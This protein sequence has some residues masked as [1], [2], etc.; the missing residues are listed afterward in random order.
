[1]ETRAAVTMATAIHD[2][3]IADIVELVTDDDSSTRANLKHPYGSWK[4]HLE[5]KTLAQEC[6][7]KIS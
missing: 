1:M 5:Q 2:T 6:K 3:G 7:R 4:Q